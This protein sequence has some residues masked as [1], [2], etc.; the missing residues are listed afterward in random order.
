V[1][2][3]HVLRNALIPI[4][5]ASGVTVASLIA[6]TVVVETAFGLDGLGSLLV[7]SVTEKDFAVAQAISLILVVAFIVINGIVDA[8]YAIVDPRI[9]RS[10]R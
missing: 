3:R 8:L 2:R 7:Q 4:T 1:L 6:G 10:R 5:T 9:R